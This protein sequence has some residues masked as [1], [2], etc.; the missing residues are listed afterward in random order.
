MNRL[1]LCG[2]AACLIAITGCR[3]AKGDT[4]EEKHD[5]AL[6]MRDDT[7]A[8][9]YQLKPY[10]KRE[11]ESAPGYA[12]FSNLGSQFFITTSGHG[13]G[14]ATN[15]ETGAITHMKMVEYGAG[16]GVGV[17]DFRVVIIFRTEEVMNRFIDSGWEFGG[18][19]EAAA[20]TKTSGDASAGAGS[21]VSDMKIYQFTEQGL[22]LQLNIKG[23]KYY[24]NKKLNRQMKGKMG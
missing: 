13:F 16:A 19:A 18:E 17:K 23:T 20:K 9:L 4:P 22:A 3:T 21:M 24:R 5:Y 2:I 14:V 12:V 6:A 7:I 1:A 15:N 11:V 8:E 10:A